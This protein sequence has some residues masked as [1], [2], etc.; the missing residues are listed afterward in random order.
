MV[1]YPKSYLDAKKR[2]EKREVSIDIPSTDSGIFE[3]KK[4][5]ILNFKFKTGL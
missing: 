5:T 2:L 3:R 4:K 1:E